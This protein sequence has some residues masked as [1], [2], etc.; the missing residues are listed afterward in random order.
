LIKSIGFDPIW[1]GVF[2]TVMSTVGLIS[3][4]VGLTVF[5]VQSQNPEVS[6]QTIFKGV[7]PFLYA[8][9]LLLLGLVMYP[10][11]ATWLPS[12]L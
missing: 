1:F 3:P 10:P 12:M 4:P 2:V 5:V 8:D 6:L 9:I 7:M 11:L